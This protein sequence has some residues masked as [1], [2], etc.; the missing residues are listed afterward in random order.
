MVTKVPTKLHYAIPLD[1]IDAQVFEHSKYTIV[2]ICDVKKI[3]I[4][5]DLA[6]YI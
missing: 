2:I 3:R 6:K 5:R 1:L 4:V